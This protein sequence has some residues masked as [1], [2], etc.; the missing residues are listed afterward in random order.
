MTD[1]TV[2]PEADAEGMDKRVEIAAFRYSLIRR[3]LDHNL[4][5]TQRG[6]LVR[7]QAAAEHIDPFGRRVR[8]SRQTLDRWIRDWKRAGFEALLPRQRRVVYRTPGNVLA[9]ATVINSENPS[10]SVGEILSLLRAH[11]GWAPSASTLRRHL[12]RLMGV[13]EPGTARFRSRQQVSTIPAGS[14]DFCCQT[15][16]LLVA[17]RPDR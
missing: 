2:R 8:V 16:P 9:L 1:A 12:P 3:A 14:T 6:R 4:S 13:T 10:L 15:V 5:P 17:G 11:F 7:Q